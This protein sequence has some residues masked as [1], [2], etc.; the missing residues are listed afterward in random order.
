MR[1][2]A[3]IVAMIPTPFTNAPALAADVEAGFEKSPRKR[4]PRAFKRAKWALFALLTGIILACVFGTLTAVQVGPFARR[5]ATEVSAMNLKRA[6]AASMPHHLSSLS[7]PDM[8]TIV[9]STASPSASPTETASPQPVKR[10]MFSLLRD[11]IT[12][13]FRKLPPL[14]AT[15][16]WRPGA[17]GLGEPGASDVSWGLVD[18]RDLSWPGDGDGNPFYFSFMNPKVC[19]PLDT[20]LGTC[21]KDW[22]FKDGF[23]MRPIPED[24]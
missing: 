18:R 7:P 11:L 12:F 6:A 10:T 16:V 23:R 2:I 9:N 20:I 4:H 3:R 21:G 19:G 17:T 8:P 5:D 22:S 13:P 14:L 15:E 1:T 24:E